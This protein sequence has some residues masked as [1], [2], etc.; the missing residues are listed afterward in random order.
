MGRAICQGLIASG[1]VHP[2]RLTVVEPVL[3]RRAQLARD[4]GVRCTPSSRPAAADADLLVLAVKPQV[5]ASV[6]E[7]LRR[8][9]SSGSL[10]LSV[11]AGTSTSAIA[12][13]LSHGAVVRAMP[14][15]A[16]QIGRSITVWY[17]TPAVSARQRSAARAVLGAI[18]EAIEVDSEEQLDRATALSGS[19]PA[20]ACLMVE[21]I[22]EGG[23]AIGFPRSLALRLATS[24]LQ[25]TASLLSQ[26]GTHP[27][28]IR[29]S[30]TSPGGTTA[31]GVLAL[32][33]RAVRAAYMEAVQA[34]YH[35]ARELG[36]EPC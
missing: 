34:A 22:V 31:A 6:A 2:K 25:G 14:N 27:A 1:L 10:V 26:E 16:A 29:E 20:F 30:I 5:F 35:R 13:Q 28:L 3:E 21:A 4:L 7:E 9:I 15:A 23:V 24:T 32:E 33:Q 36:S 11:M 8:S 12:S 17:A 18:G 19:G